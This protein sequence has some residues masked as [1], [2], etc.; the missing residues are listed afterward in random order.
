MSIGTKNISLKKTDLSMYERCKSFSYNHPTTIKTLKVSLVIFILAS[1]IAAFYLKAP[2]VCKAIPTI[3]SFSILT[4]L[5]KRASAAST[6]NTSSSK[7][8]GSFKG[9]FLYF[10]PDQPS[11]NEISTDKLWIM[12]EQKTKTAMQSVT[13]LKTTDAIHR[14]TDISCPKNTA[15]SIEGN[16]LHAN[17]VKAVNSKHLFIASQ[18]PVKED[19][20]LFWKAV[21][22]KSSLI[23]DLTTLE[24]QKLGVIKY[25]PDALNE[26]K[27]FRSMQ[28]KLIKINNNI[29]TYEV[30]DKSTG[31]SKIINRLH[32]STWKDFSAVTEDNL[33]LLIEKVEKLPSNLTDATWVHCR[34]GVGRT[35]TLITAMILKEKIKKGEVTKDNLDTV[36][37]DIIIDLRKQRGEHFVQQEVQLALLRQYANFLFR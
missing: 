14:F 27:Q 20:E 33:A 30:V 21:F 26:I 32:H 4:S 18:A 37:I 2:L 11:T 9:K 13:H 28:V 24:D 8:S 3:I 25:Y 7:V 12:L 31:Q 29:F 5:F 15:V 19:L 16:F 35:G 1:T 34:A 23:I 22:E 17:T 36:L 6:T 10:P